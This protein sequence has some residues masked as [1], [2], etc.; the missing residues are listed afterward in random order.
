MS[1]VRLRDL[2][3]LRDTVSLIDGAEPVEIRPVRLPEIVRLV[4]KY[5]DAF[6]ALYNE[7]QQE[8]PSY[9]N[10]IATVP[11]LVADIICMGAEMHDQRDDVVNLPPGPQL[12]L[13]ARI[14]AL[15]VPDPKKLIESLSTLMAQAKRL[16]DEARARA[17]LPS[18]TSASATPGDSTSSSVN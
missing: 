8:N 16:A 18:G 11:D 13:L 15:S 14:W 6:V 1:N 3:P 17:S 5:G 4:G 10:F 9:E 12:Q 7:S 2:F